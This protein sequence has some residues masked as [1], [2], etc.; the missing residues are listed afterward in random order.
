MYASA[1]GKQ[2]K[3]F[4][5][6]PC[7]EQYIDHIPYYL[8]GLSSAHFSDNLSRNSCIQNLIILH[9]IQFFLLSFKERWLF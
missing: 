2:K 1:E 9:F 8:S 7:E 4:R 3:S 6:L 5:L